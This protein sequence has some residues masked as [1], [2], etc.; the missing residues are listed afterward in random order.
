MSGLTAPERFPSMSRYDPP[1]KK[2]PLFSSPNTPWSGNLCGF[3]GVGCEVKQYI[4][5]AASSSFFIYI[6]NPTAPTHTHTH[7]AFRAMPSLWEKVSRGEG[8]TP[9][10]GWNALAV[11]WE[12][13]EGAIGQPPTQLKERDAIAE[14]STPN[15]NNSPTAE[16]TAHTH[17]LTAH[18]HPPRPW[19]TCQ[20]IPLGY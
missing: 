11:G 6:I 17:T 20:R 7:V 14:L 16:H 4:I 10:L 8:P 13:W 3:R 1:R 15:E 2:D 5:T 19:T 18:P 12:R 9:N